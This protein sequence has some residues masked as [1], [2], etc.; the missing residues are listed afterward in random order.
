[1]TKTRNQFIERWS[2]AEYINAKLGKLVIVQLVVIVLLIFGT[3]FIT[4]S[5][6]P[7]YYISP[8]GVGVSFPTDLPESVVGVFTVAWLMNWVNFTPSIVDKVY[9]R[10]QQLMTP[11]LWSRTQQRLKEDLDEIRQN[12]MSSSF[13]IHEDPKI[14]RKNDKYQVVIKGQKSIYVNNQQIS[15]QPMMFT[16]I[17]RKVSPTQINPY[18]LMIEELNQDIDK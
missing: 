13:S 14:E 17:V 1:M 3:I 10:A 6:K 12:N 18:G 8:Q 5:P 4:I 2:K 9:E 11:G 15:V 7:I 16:V